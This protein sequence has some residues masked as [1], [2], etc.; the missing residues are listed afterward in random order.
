[1]TI[2]IYLL[3][4]TVNGKQYVGQSW[5]IQKRWGQHKRAYGR[6][7]ISNAIKKYGW[8]LF[9]KAIIHIVDNY[10]DEITLQSALDHYETFYIRKYSTREFGYN[11]KDGGHHAK[12]SEETKQKMSVAKKGRTFSDEHKSNLSKAHKGKKRQPM[13]DEQKMKISL[14]NLG[15]KHPPRSEEYKENLRNSLKSRNTEEYRRMLSVKQK[16]VSETKSICP[17]CNREISKSNMKRHIAA[18]HIDK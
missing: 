9:D 13:T 1:M 15:K 16:G 18:R 8:D 14:A 3:T 12:P 10:N 11:N 7:K 4:N 17:H 6:Q 2:G 5:D